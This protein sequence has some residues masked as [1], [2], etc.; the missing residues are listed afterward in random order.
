[1]NH[2]QGTAMW[3]RVARPSD[4]RYRKGAC[5]QDSGHP[6][7]AHAYAR[8]PPCS[9]PRVQQPGITVIRSDKLNLSS[10]VDLP[11]FYALS[12]VVHHAFAR[13]FQEKIKSVRPT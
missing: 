4:S 10:L 9:T 2:L 11:A 12:S 3:C 1:M 6:V 8:P 13:N 7:S 5:A